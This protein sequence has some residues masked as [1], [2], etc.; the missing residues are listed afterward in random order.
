MVRCSVD[1]SSD[2]YFK[3]GELSRDQYS[4]S[5]SRV[6]F[7]KEL[8]KME[9]KPLRSASF[10]NTCVLRLTVLP[11]IYNS[12]SV[13]IN[14]KDSVVSVTVKIAGDDPDL[15]RTGLDNLAIKYESK[16]SRMD[17]LFNTLLAVTNEYDFYPGFGEVEYQSL[18]GTTYLIEYLT[19]KGD[20][21][22]VVGKAQGSYKGK[23]DLIKV[24]THLHQFIPYCLIPDLDKA[25]VLNDVLF[26]IFQRDAWPN[27]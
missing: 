1:K 6:Y 7:E 23:E 10:Q 17:S 4:D 12:Y 8:M 3:D 2:V 5:T 21:K 14:R 13:Q 27:D 24:V 9:E 20:Y 19:D 25:V 22:S 26:P 18:H 16:G 11:S 15:E